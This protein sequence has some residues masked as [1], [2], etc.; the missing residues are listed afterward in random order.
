MSFLRAILIIAR[1]DS[2]F[3]AMLADGTYKAIEQKYEHLQ[4]PKK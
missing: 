4:A 2:A 1:M 3:K